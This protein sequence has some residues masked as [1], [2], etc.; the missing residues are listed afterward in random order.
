VS[1][2]PPG[3]APP[4]TLAE[5]DGW[6]LD[7]VSLARTICEHYDRIYP[8]ERER[9][10]PGGR[11]WCHHDNQ[12]LLS[13]AAAD[14]IGAVDLNE[15]A[16]WLARVLHSRGFPIERLVRNLMLAAEVIR[17]S[18]LGPAGPAVAERLESAST[19]VAGLPLG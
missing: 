5:V 16:C 18:E 9:Y 4:P 13:W 1:T 14:V 6:Q 8:D 3:G 19:V 11:Q 12:W 10:G 7:L 2:R 15:Q 17:E